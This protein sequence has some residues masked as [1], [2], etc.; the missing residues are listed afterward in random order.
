MEKGKVTWFDTTK[1]YG[2]IAP[3]DGSEDIFV[4]ISEVESAGYTS[5]TKNQT[6]RYELY[7]KNGKSYV[8]NLQLI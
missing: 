6:I 4:H 8:I 2:F 1:G 3:D 7:T 5:L